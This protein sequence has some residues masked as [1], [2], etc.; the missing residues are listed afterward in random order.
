MHASL[1]LFADCTPS[2]LG[3]DLKWLN[4]PPDWRLAE[5]ELSVTPEAGTDFFRPVGDPPFDNAGLLYTEASGDFTAVTHA[6][7]HLVGFGDAAAI[8]VRAG[9]DRWAKL[10]IERS[11]LGEVSI[12]SVVTAPWSD[13][14]NSE[15]LDRPAR[16]LRITRRGD[17]LGM[18]HSADGELW[19]FVRACH[20]ELPGT[21][22][23]GVHA[24]APFVGGSQ[25]TFRLLYVRPEP[26]QDFRSG[27]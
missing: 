19:R 16:Y 21:V 11:P 24:Q 9:S 6:E 7:A 2:R 5:G 4:E 13:D 25:A 15:L 26:V 14:A 22:M 1:N 10:C 3:P 27:E 8:T 23:V 18:H 20:L 12:V 17:L